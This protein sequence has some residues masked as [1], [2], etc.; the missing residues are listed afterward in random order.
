MKQS[1]LALFTLLGQ[2]AQKVALSVEGTKP[3]ATIEAGSTYD[4]ALLMPEIAKRAI[5]AAETYK[6]FFIFEEY[7]RDFMHDSL[8]ADPAK[9]WWTFIPADI[10][11]EVEEIEQKEETKKWMALNARGKISLFT[12]PQLLKTIEENW[13]DHFKDLVLDKNL[14]YQA[15]LLVHLRN[16]ICHMND[17]TVEENNRIKQVMRDWFRVIAP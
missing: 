1:D 12:L 16:N 11:K 5:S 13:K 14:I 8:S 17:I 3:P 4:L 2:T 10:K 6:L 15:R 7:L 9:D